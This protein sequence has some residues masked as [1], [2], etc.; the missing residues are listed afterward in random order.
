MLA[1]SS[2]KNRITETTRKEI[3]STMKLQARDRLTPAELIDHV[4]SILGD[5]DFTEDQVWRALEETQF[6]AEKAVDH[7]LNPPKKAPAKPKNDKKADKKKGNHDRDLLKNNPKA[8]TR[9]PS[10][11]SRQPTPR[12]QR[13]QNPS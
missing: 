10:R 2:R 4:Y 13:T 9:K 11:T 7:L 5:C 6:D 12:S 8:R 3:T 1:K